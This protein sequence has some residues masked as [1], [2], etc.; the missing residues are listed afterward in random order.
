M[1]IVFSIVSHGQQDLVQRLLKSMDKFVFSKKHN[2]R[3]LVTENIHGKIDVKSKKFSIT[4][5]SNIRKKG[6]GSNHNAAFEKLHSDYFFIVNPDICF[7]HRVNIDD[8]IKQME[9]EKVDIASP[10]IVNSLGQVEDY[11]RADIGVM[12]L[13]KR[14]LFKNKSEKFEW[15]AGMFLVVRSSSFCQLEGFDT[16]FFMYVEDCDLCMRARHS[17]MRLKDLDSFTVY[18]QA[19]RATKKSTEHLRWHISSLLKYIIL[20]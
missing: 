14:C 11:K 15:F 5:I 20:K 6:F 1:N 8:A 13:L 7:L 10:K 4:Y 16:D 17:G 2:I 18:H 9:N 12:N 19:R 3:I